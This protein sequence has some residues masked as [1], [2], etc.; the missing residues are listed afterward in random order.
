[1][2]AGANG[3]PKPV[4]PVVKIQWM[5]ELAISA[6]S[7]GTFKRQPEKFELG[8]LRFFCDHVGVKSKKRHSPSTPTFLSKVSRSSIFSTKIVPT[9]MIDALRYKNFSDCQAGEPNPTSNFKLS[10]KID[11]SKVK[12]HSDLIRPELNV[13]QP[14]ANSPGKHAN[15]LWIFDFGLLTFD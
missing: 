14:T 2:D 4:L 6:K 15:G 7:V 12:R 1:M 11:H 9:A 3:S 10:I 13:I 5:D 8:G